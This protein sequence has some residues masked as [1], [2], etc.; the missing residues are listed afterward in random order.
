[1]KKQLTFLHCADLHL[2]SPFKG[3]SDI[4]SN[5]L[6]DIRESTFTALTNLTNL[7]I[8]EKVDFVLLVG[9]IFDQEEQSMRAHIALRKTLEKLNE[10]DISVYISFGNHDYINSQ[11]FPR[12][13]PDN[14]FVFEKEKV[15]AFEFIKNNEQIAKIYGFS[16]EERAVIENKSL[17][18]QKTEES[19][20]H[21]ATL[22][23]T[24]GN[25][26]TEEHTPYAPFQLS[27]LKQAGFDYWALGHIHKREVLSKKPSI[28]YP[29][30]IQ[31]R[32]MKET[33][34]KGCYLVTLTETE[35]QLDFHQLH[36]IRFEKCTISTESWTDIHQ[37]LEDIEKKL[38]EFSSGMHVVELQLQQVTTTVQEWINNGSFDEILEIINQS[39]ETKE[40][41]YI[42]GYKWQKKQQ[43]SEWIQDGGFLQELAQS[44]STKEDLVKMLAELWQHPEGRKWLD[45]LEKEEIEVTIM[46]A[47]QLLDQLLHE[48][49]G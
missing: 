26:K 33:G 37:V 12:N 17:Q 47:E 45:K 8:Q 2:D 43:R 20:Y 34:E 16:Y 35:Q 30:N 4:P 39:I 23:G 13:Y 9:D 11:T 31:G 25:V 15:E 24:F 49:G 3:L 1:M 22:H 10:H 28:V 40:W 48:K 44:F 14:V 36:S 29:G 21:I 27:D 18:F 6:A 46:E 41:T 42:S 32:S 5:I 7:A 19:I 38:A